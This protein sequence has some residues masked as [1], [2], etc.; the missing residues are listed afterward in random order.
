ML[1][2]SVNENFLII[3]FVVLFLRNSAVGI[4]FCG[5][6]SVHGFDHCVSLVP[7]A[8]SD[9]GDAKSI[10]CLLP[11]FQ[12]SRIVAALVLFHIEHSP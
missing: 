3:E 8:N 11:V 5:F 12:F 1:T 6:F 9:A 7:L 10:Q 4:E 2:I